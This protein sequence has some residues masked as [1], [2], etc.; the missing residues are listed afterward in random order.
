MIAQHSVPYTGGDVLLTA[1]ELCP[2]NLIQE[3]K[4]FEAFGK[5]LPAWDLSKH[6]L[7]AVVLGGSQQLS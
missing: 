7:A 4:A 6:I 3:A 1:G 5:R 2:K